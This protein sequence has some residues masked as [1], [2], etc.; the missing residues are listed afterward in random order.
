MLDEESPYLWT[1]NQV[2]EM[3]LQHVN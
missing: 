3:L 1:S 2:V